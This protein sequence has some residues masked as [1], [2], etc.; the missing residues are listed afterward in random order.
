M[1]QRTGAPRGTLR[2]DP[3][4]GDSPRTTKASAR[5]GL[6]TSPHLRRSAAGTGSEEDCHSKEN[7]EA[8]GHPRLLLNDRHQELPLIPRCSKV[9]SADRTPS[10][11]VAV[12]NTRPGHIWCRFSV[13]R[14]VP[15]VTFP[16]SVPARSKTQAARLKRGASEHSARSRE[17]FTWQPI[18]EITAWHNGVPQQRRR[19]RELRTLTLLQTHLPPRATPSHLCTVPPAAAHGGPPRTRQVFSRRNWPE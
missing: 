13:A 4:R 8:A 19:S 14:L 15:S 11:L 16:V 9:L 5:R 10:P 3:P 12:T 2:R 7:Q 18:S 1:V 17:S 6:A